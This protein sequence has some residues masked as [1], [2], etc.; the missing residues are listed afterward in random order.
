MP[1][2]DTLSPGFIM[3]GTSLRHEIQLLQTYLNDFA[4]DVVN[5]N[6]NMVAQP[7]KT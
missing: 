7:R 4:G 6:R 5:R 2:F 3:M 1:N